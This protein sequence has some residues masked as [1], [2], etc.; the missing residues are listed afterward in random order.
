MLPFSGLVE[1][2]KIGNELG[3]DE[4]ADAAARRVLGKV[5]SI[6]SMAK[7]TIMEYPVLV[8]YSLADNKDISLNIVKTLELYYAQFTLMS[9]G[10][11]PVVDKGT[12]GMHIGKFS[13]ENYPFSPDFNVKYFATENLCGIMMKDYMS[14]EELVN[15]IHIPIKVDGDENHMGFSIIK[16]KVEDVKAMEA[17]WSEIISNESVYNFVSE[18]AK[19]GMEAG[20][21]DIN[22]IPGRRLSDDDEDDDLNSNQPNDRNGNPISPYHSANID[23]KSGY[24]NKLAEDIAKEQFKKFLS[25]AHPTLVTV[26]LYVGPCQKPVQVTLGIKAMPHFV[27]KEELT[28]LFESVFESQKRHFRWLKLRSGEISFFKDYLL[29][30]DR[31]QKDKKLYASLGR[32]PW[33]RRLM[34]KKNKSMF[35]AIVRLIPIVKNFIRDK[36]ILPT[37]TLLVS[38]DEMAYSNMS[39]QYLQRNQK[40]IYKIMDE[41]M[42]LA[43]VVYDSVGDL[44]Y[45]YFNGFENP[46]VYRTSDLTKGSGGS[47]DNTQDL[48]KIM[49]KMMNLY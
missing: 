1:I 4:D 29:N 36:R 16:N 10:L 22:T 5:D 18:S 23:A 12:V 34:A 37:C 31:I 38:A 33:Y 30:M 39:F 7:K 2:S 47:S 32:H 46:L 20:I 24:A 11:N 9:A 8:S 40:H 41:L 48:I 45:F 13:G 35:Q 6:A 27:G 43:L 14:A 19:K 49:N 26:N 28:S 25:A 17:L 3:V 42:L 15:T 44:V 21:S